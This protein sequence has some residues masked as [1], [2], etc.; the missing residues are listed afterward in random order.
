MIFTSLVV[1]VCYENL[2]SYIGKIGE[3]EDVIGG[4]VIKPAQCNQLFNI[5]F[6]FFSLDF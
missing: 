4:D 3:T 6:S 1:T 5:Q 2:F